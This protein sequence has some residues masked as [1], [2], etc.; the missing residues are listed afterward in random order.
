MYNLL[1]TSQQGAWDNTF[2]E[3]DKSRFLEY[4]NEKFATRFQSLTERKIADLKALPCIFAYEGTEENIRIGYLT[5][6]KVRPRTLLIEYK[7]HPK[8]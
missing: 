7:F 5:S 2:Y 4:T 6:I 8:N 1:V 3:F